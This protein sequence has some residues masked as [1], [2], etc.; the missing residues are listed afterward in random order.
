MTDE[1]KAMKPWETY[2]AGAGVRLLRIADWDERFPWLSAGFT[3]R[4]GGVSAPPWA[5]LNVGLHVGDDDGD[6]AE[7]RRRVAEAAGF[8]FE[9]WTCAE[10]VHGCEVAVVRASEAGAGRLSRADAI[11]SKDALV[12]DAPGLMLNAFYADCVP[13]WFVDPA[14]RAVGLAHAGWRGAVA[15]VAGE[16]VRA[17]ARAFGTVPSD[18]HAAVGPSIRGCCYE[19]DDA[20]AQHIPADSGALKRSASPGRYLL[21]LAI[22]NRQKL[23]EAG[24]MPNRIEI[25]QYC[26]GCRTDLFF[27]HRRENGRTGRMTAWIARKGQVTHP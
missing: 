25:N 9:A 7:N 2:S 22:F 15:D 23:T 1:A 20:V 21:D 19:V 13:L 4:V 16:T 3:T 12:T 8:G 26:T 14:N 5:S 10:Q 17:M 24:I 18:V 27:S 11:P 6:V